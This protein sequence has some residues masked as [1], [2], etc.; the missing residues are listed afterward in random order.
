MTGNYELEYQHRQQRTQG[1]NDYTF[2]AQDAGYIGVGPYRP[3]HGYDD[4]RTGDYHHG[5]EKQRQV[6]VEIKDVMR[7]H[8]CDHPAYQRTDG[9]E[10]A[11]DFCEP[12]DLLEAQ[13][14]A[15]FKQDDGDGQ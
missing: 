14:E 8:R 11:D 12:P 9:D 1:I 6:D 10:I 3:Q 2:P 7:R 5:T 4:G 15:A 13:G